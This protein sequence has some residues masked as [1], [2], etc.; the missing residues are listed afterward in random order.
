MLVSPARFW[1]LNQSKYL[2]AYLK[3]KFWSVRHNLNKILLKYSW[4]WQN[5]FIQLIT[6]RQLISVQTR[7]LSEQQQLNEYI[8]NYK[9]EK[10]LGPTKYGHSCLAKHI[11]TGEKVFIKAV[12]KDNK[13]DLMY[14]KEYN[15][16]SIQQEIMIQKWLVNP[17]IVNVFE[18]INTPNYLYVIMEYAENGELFEYLK[19]KKRFTEQQAGRIFVQLINGINYCHSKK[20]CHRNLKLENILLDS[21]LNVK[22]SNFEYASLLEDD[23]MLSIICGTPSYASPEL[24]SKKKFDGPLTDVWACGIILFAMLCGYLPFDDDD[25][26]NLYK[27]IKKG[28]FQI[29]T[30][31]SPI[32]R[33]LI[34]KILVIDPNQRISISQIM[35]Y[36]WFL[37]NA[38]LRHK[39]SYIQR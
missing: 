16:N 33:D 3:C 31:V 9:T 15:K 24:L 38:R 34:S 2:K 14:Q 13:L 21:H 1:F 7:L 22:I 4:S 26:K 23:N 11:I 19:Q 32:A 10:Q 8:Q 27:K 18:T 6:T 39:L 20:V 5:K 25:L 12:E 30:Y 37:K 17:Y 35:Q 28:Q 36:P 29:P